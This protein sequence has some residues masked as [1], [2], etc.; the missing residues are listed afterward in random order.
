MKERIYVFTSGELKREGNT[1]CFVSETGKRFL[2]I[3]ETGEIYAFGEISLN[4][5]LLEFL[6]SNEITLHFF[7]Y[8]G[9]YIG[10]FYPREHYNSGYMTL[11]QA[12]H[13]LNQKTRLELASKFVS[14]AIENMIKNLKYYNSRGCDLENPI[15][16]MQETQPNLQVVGV[17]KLMA[18]EGQAREEY[19]T[20][21]NQIIKNPEYHYTKRTRRPPQSRLDSLISFGNS[22]LY[23]TVLGEIYKTHL[24]PRI[25][26]LHT[27]NFRKFTLNLDV[28]EV[29]K[30]LIVDRVIFTLTNKN[31]LTPSNFM[32][33][34][35][36]VLLNEKG[37][38]TFVEEY[39]KKLQTTITHKTLKRKVSYHRLIRMELYKIEKH[40]I[41]EQ[42]Y[43]PYTAEW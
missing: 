43:T 21:F 32:K 24:D 13:Y 10:S 22:L 30:P 14:G 20:A 40:L 6:S 42:S 35:D 4:K 2:P 26:F 33:E 39:E 28:A 15:N 3:A 8:Y 27:T 36:G 41:G 19:Y 38:K 7:N 1:L 31:M 16:K 5:K 25:G 17:D 37:R 9:Y 23:T 12:E 11:H 18:L 29:F 34:L